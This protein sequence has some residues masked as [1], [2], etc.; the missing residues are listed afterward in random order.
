MVI[1]VAKTETIFLAF[2]EAQIKIQFSVL[3]VNCMYLVCIVLPMVVA[4]GSYYS[5][6][7]AIK[8]YNVC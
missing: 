7:L 6:S 8:K 5:L 3:L 2:F 1:T 4:Q